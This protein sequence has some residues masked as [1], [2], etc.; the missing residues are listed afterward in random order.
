MGTTTPDEAK[1]C[2]DLSLAA[3]AGEYKGMEL[4]ETRSKTS[5]KWKFE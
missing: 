3:I 1:E 4:Q 2:I 5:V